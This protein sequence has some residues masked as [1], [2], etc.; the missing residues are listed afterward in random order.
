MLGNEKS[1]LVA[2]YDLMGLLFMLCSRSD[3]VTH[4]HREKKV[5]YALSEMQDFLSIDNDGNESGG[6]SALCVGQSF[7]NL[8]YQLAMHLGV[9]LYI[10]LQ[11]CIDLVSEW[12]RLNIW[13]GIIDEQ[14]MPYFFFVVANLLSDHPEQAITTL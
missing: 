12:W 14:V 7:T 2:K 5:N 1:G 3:Y 6:S 9:I 10:F 11:P 4:L 13:Q 8:I